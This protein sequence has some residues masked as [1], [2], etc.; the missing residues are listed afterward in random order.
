MMQNPR[1]LIEK[2]FVWFIN[3]GGILIFLISIISI[4]K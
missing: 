2:A 4:I 3:I 1:G